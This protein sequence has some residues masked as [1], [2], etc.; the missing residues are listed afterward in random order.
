MGSLDLSGVMPYWPAL[1]GGQVGPEGQ[2][3]TDASVEEELREML[4]YYNDIAEGSGEIV[5]PREQR[6]NSE[7]DA[8]CAG[9][10]ATWLLSAYAM[11]IDEIRKGPPNS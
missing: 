6:D 7:Y 9:L 4:G 11:D 5:L 10:G 1:L 8:L 2:Q 3:P